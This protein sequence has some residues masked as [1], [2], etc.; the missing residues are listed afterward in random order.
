VTAIVSHEQNQTKITEPSCRG[1]TS[2][3]FKLNS[4]PKQAPAAS[5]LASRELTGEE[6]FLQKRQQAVLTFPRPLS[7]QPSLKQNKTK[8]NKRPWVAQFGK[9]TFYHLTCFQPRHAAEVVVFRE[10]P[11]RPRRNT[12][13][14]TLYCTL[15]YLTYSPASP[16]ARRRLWHL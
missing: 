15:P 2:F 12:T 10:S 4:I 7:S 11:L 16:P 9:Y 14:P 1:C 13:R 3:F 5:E 6:W 8:Q